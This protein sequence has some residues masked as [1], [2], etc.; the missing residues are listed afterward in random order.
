[1]D[2]N[3]Y[4]SHVQLTDEGV[5]K[6]HEG[7]HIAIDN[8]KMT[9][10]DEMI[11]LVYP[12]SINATKL[13]PAFIVIGGN[14]LSRGLTIEGL[15]STFFLRKTNQ[16]DTLMQMGRW[17]GYRKGYEIFPR[18]WM[19]YDA[20][21]RFQFLSQLD[22]EL[23]SNLVE[24]SKRN[25]TPIEVAPKIK[26]SPDYQLVR[27]TSV[28]KMQ[29]AISAEFN[30]S[31]FNSQTVFFKDDMEQLAHNFCLTE[32]F[33]NSLGTPQKSPTSD[34][35]LVWKDIDSVQVENFLQEYQVISEDKRMATINNLIEWLKEN[36]HTINDWNIVLSSKGKIELADVDSDW[37]IHGYN[38]KGVTRTKLVPGSNG[39]IVSIGVLRQP[40][41]LIADIDELNPEE[42]K[43]VLMKDIRDLRSSK[44]FEKTPLLVIYRIDKDSEPTNKLSKRREKLNFSHDIIGI[45]ILIPRFID[46]STKNITT[47]LMPLIKSIDD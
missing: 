38:P 44:G 13:A 32:T 12:N 17:F 40:D 14:T 22:Y 41:D 43:V 35:K 21:E 4:L 31:G 20:Y 24:Y 34:S 37:N 18:V 7:F 25:L 46:V 28:N 15:V 5:P 2:D 1:M 30:F 39:E 33:L 3:E 11:R 23:R 6:Y 36:N 27:I 26:N 19:E 45:N 8:S 16:A 10:A 47:Q 9:S 42:K 29:S